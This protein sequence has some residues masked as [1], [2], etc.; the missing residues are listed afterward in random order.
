MN[1]VL[2]V[3]SSN[4]RSPWREGVRVRGNKKKILATNIFLGFDR[5]PPADPAEGQKKALLPFWDHVIK[6]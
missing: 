6:V 3:S 4:P 2:K 1:K 5:H